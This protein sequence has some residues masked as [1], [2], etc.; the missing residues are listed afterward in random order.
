MM[1]FRTTLALIAVLLPAVGAR[2]QLGY[3]KVETPWYQQGKIAGGVAVATSS[4]ATQLP[5]AGMIAAICNTGANDVYLAFGTNNTVTAAVTTS[6][7]LRAGRCAS[8]DLNPFTTRFTWL[9]AIAPGGSSTL[10]VETGIG[11]PPSAANS[12]SAFTLSGIT[13]DVIGDSRMADIVASSTCGAPCGLSGT[14]FFAQASAQAGQRYQLGL[15]KAV[16]GCRTDQYLQP[17]NFAPI[18]SSKSQYVIFGYP[19]INDIGQAGTGCTILPSAGTFPYTN[20]MGQLVNLATVASTGAGNIIAA[21]KQAIGAGKKVVISLEPGGSWVSSTAGVV[22]TFVGSTA[23]QTSTSGILTVSS[24]T[25]GSTIV[26]GEQLNGSGVTGSP[27]IVGSALTNPQL[28]TPACTGAGG[29]G[30]YAISTNQ[31]IASQ[32]FTGIYSALAAVYEA[33][34][35]LTAFGNSYPGQVCIYN[36]GPALWAPTASATTMGFK[37]QVLIDGLIHYGWTGGTYGGTALNSQCGD[38]MGANTPDQSIASIDYVWPNNPRSLT[39]N[40]L[41]QTA[42]GGSN[43]NCTLSSGTVPAGWSTSCTASAVTALTITQPADPNGYGND[44]VIA[45]TASGAD[46]LRITMST[47]SNAAWSPTDYIQFNAVVSVAASSSNCT[48]YGQSSYNTDAGNIDTWSLFGGVA[49]SGGGSN[50]GP[51][52]AYTVTLRTPPA[53]ALQ[54]ATVK[55]FIISRV[56]VVF[57]AAGSCTVTI[58]RPSLSRARVYDPVTGTFSGWLLMRDLDPAANDNSPAWLLKVG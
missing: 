43:S 40:P 50:N 54:N 26:V 42:T 16:S 30:T 2:A 48:V 5:A 45:A 11:N 51:T 14:N 6:T 52:T 31:A 34:A 7:W 56:N 39:Q 23:A 8:Y 55:N 19:M 27:Q 28:C 32:T 49:A 47:P 3:G 18:L 24:I 15:M 35:Q 57:S 9:A 46:G 21:A 17:S 33:N 44:L 53:Q 25:S 1:I 10:T 13:A 20:Q 38:F 22:V 36:P 12:I 29:T 4:A 37:P 58:A 41:F